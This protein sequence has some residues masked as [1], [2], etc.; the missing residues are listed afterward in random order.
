MARVRARFIGMLQDRQETIAG[1]AVAAWDARS[2]EDISGHLRAAQ[3]VLHQIAGTAGSLGFPDLGT[4]A[5]VCENEIID[6]LNSPDSR[7]P[8]CP[9]EIIFNL[10]QFLQDCQVVLDQGA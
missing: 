3:A 9:D 1:H 8:R 10:D 7:K 2:V 5:H 6:H 4:K